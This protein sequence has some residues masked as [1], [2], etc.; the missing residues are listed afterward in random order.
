MAR[1]FIRFQDQDKIVWGE[2]A[3]PAPH[4]PGDRVTLHSLGAALPTTAALIAAL[5][6]GSDLGRAAAPCTIAARDILSPVTTDAAV[7]CQGLN[8]Q[9]HSSGD[10]GIHV[11][12]SNLLFMKASSALCGP[13]DDILKPASV[14]MLDYEVEVGL[15]LRRGIEAGT[16]V[17]E[18]AI[19]S[20]IAGAVL[21]N[22]VSARDTMFG[23]TYMQWFQGKSYRTFLPAGPVFYWFEPGEV[24]AALKQL[25][26]TLDWRGET[27]QSATTEQMIFKPAETLSYIATVM[28]MKRGDLL[29]SGTPGG[30]IAKGTP[31]INQI[32]RD[33]LLED[34]ER[35]SRFVVE[36]HATVS[37]F[38]QVGDQI[39]TTMEDLRAG[40]DLG[41]QE[42]NVAALV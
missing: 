1:S 33:F 14:E 39:V 37:D 6:S 31:V 40:V 42:S 25:K 9:S 13:Y 35:R 7:V 22:D 12:K 3:G 18:E 19:G 20:Y 21:C 5:D 2:L 28:D 41:G 8:Y 24:E 34:S 10:A 36:A 17:A 11:R 23:A 29:L 4:H 30:V 27:R 38:M 32:L 15:V 26:I 16:T